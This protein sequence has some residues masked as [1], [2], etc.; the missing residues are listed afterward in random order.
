MNPSLRRN[1]CPSLDAPM[2]TGDGL[3]VRINTVT[4]AISPRHL[5]LIAEA[6]ARHGNGI[7]EVTRRGSLQVRGLTAESAP[8]FSNEVLE[9]GIDIR[10]GVPVETGPLAGL[11]ATEIADPTRIASQLIDRI[12]RTDLTDR[13]GPKVSVVVDGGGQLSMGDVLADVRLTALAGS[14]GVR[15]QIALGGTAGTAH[16]VGVADDEIAVELALELLKAI[17]AQGR[18]GRAKNL[19]KADISK[20]CESWTDQLRVRSTLPPSVLPDIPPPR[21]EIGSFDGGT[22]TSMAAKLPIGSF[23]LTH[24]RTA[25]GLGLPF[26][27]ASPDQLSALTQGAENTNI[28]EF[29]L[30]PGHALLVICET[31]A[32]AKEFGQVATGLGFIVDPRNPRLRIVACAGAPACSSGLIQTKEIA[33]KIAAAGVFSEGGGVRSETGMV[34]ISGCAKG[35]AEPPSP[36]FTILG[37]PDGASILKGKIDG[38]ARAGKSE[39][40]HELARVAEGNIPAAFQRALAS[41]GMGRDIKP[42]PRARHRKS[43]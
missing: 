43:A 39:P 5:A 28:S 38:P 20:A 12:G 35:C 14:G 32:Q 9:S 6:A 8:A 13:L 10:M 15:W 25:L 33:A 16:V 27:Q 30:A 3:L 7:L 31:A 22:Q 26:G 4:G 34:H 42:A 17:A 1:A 36:A 37:T 18:W 19:T 21:G 11:D 29:R 24:G 2:H 23:A 41:R 40:G